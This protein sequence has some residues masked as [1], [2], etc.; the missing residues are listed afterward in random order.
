[1]IKVGLG[2]MGVLSGRNQ[3]I[4]THKAEKTEVPNYMFALVFTVRCFRYCVKK[5]KVGTGE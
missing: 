1:M 4:S 5:A 2:K 3:E